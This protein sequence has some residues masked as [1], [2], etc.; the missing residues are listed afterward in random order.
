MEHRFKKCIDCAVLVVL[1]AL[2]QLLHELYL[3]LFSPRGKV[4]QANLPLLQ[5]PEKATIRV[6]LNVTKCIGK[7]RTVDIKYRI[8]NLRIGIKAMADKIVNRNFPCVT[9]HFML[10]KDLNSLFTGF[11]LL[12]GDGF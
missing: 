3:I 7:P 1:H 9:S 10:E 11:P 4:I 2:E 12:G 6:C 8:R 5:I